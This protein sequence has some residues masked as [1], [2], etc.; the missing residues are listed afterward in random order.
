M[1]EAQFIC[2]PLAIY[3]LFRIPR[4]TGGFWPWKCGNADAGQR[5]TL[6]GIWFGFWV[7]DFFIFLFLFLFFRNLRD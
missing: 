3:L 2:P 1:Y 7:V 5:K 4:C 6:G